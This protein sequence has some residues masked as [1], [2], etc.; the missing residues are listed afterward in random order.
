MYI[1]N[2]YITSGAIIP[3]QKVVDGVITLQIVEGRLT[4]IV[5]EDNKY[6]N[7]S[8]YLKRIELGAGP[9]VKVDDLQRQ[10]GLLQQ[11]QR[12]K[13]LDANLKAGIKPGESNLNLT[14]EEKL[15][16]NLWSGYNNYIA[17]SVGGEQVL[18]AGSALSLTGH[19]D[20]FS[21][22][23]GEAE[24]LK[25]KVDT[26]YSLPLTARDLT[27]GL[28]YRKNDFDIVRE[29]FEDLDIETDTDIYL[30]SM[31]YPLF[32][33]LKQEFGLTLLGEHA[34]RKTT[35]LNQPFSLEPGAVDGKVKVTT[36]R[37]A[38]EYV[39]RTQS[40]VIAA[41]SQFSLGVDALDAT[42]RKEG[43][44]DGEFFKWQGQFQWVR[45]FKTLDS[46]LLFRS[47]VQLTD[48]PLVSLEQATVGG[49]Y[50]VRGYPENYF[51]RDR[52]FN[53][54]LESRIPI[55]R[56]K[57]W[58]DYLQIVPFFDWGW[59]K[60]QDFPTPSGPTNIYSVGVGLRWAATF[61]PSTLRLNPQFEI[62]YGYRLRDVDIDVDNDL[63]DKGISFQIAVAAF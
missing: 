19:G 24:G 34:I 38:Q 1:K 29:P 4:E 49:R 42:I 32:R 22:T 51:V 43:L 33:D 54:S 8:Y 36:I 16:I 50:T 48:D 17:D 5:V 39:H 60:N 55:I 6:L 57:P 37:F 63:Q 47:F 41:L 52:A 11:N 35:L 9:P 2:G 3:N 26:W 56:N 25:P 10:L 28:R 15:P 20:I 58:A 13:R 30:V 18:A 62:F 40:Q 27:L 53:L 44:P 7:D 23:W 59:G 14:V 12:I 21:F 46:Q 45:R 61:F 31:R